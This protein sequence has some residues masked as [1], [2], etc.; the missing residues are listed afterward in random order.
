MDGEFSPSTTETDEHVLDLDRHERVI[1]TGRERD[2]LIRN[3]SGVPL[4]KEKR[5]RVRYVEAE[6]S[7][8]SPRQWS[9]EHTQQKRYRF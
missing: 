3:D 9:V 7:F 1:E 6:L 8:L 2:S 5:H 4:L